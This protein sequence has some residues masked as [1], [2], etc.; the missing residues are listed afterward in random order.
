MN[1]TTPQPL[2]GTFSSPGEKVIAGHVIASVRLRRSAGTA[3]GWLR[4]SADGLSETASHGQRHKLNQRVQLEAGH[5]LLDVMGCGVPGR[6]PFPA[7]RPN[8]PRLHP[9]LLTHAPP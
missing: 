3:W 2:I 6:S 9:P 4:G 8:L 7:Y 1:Q 5:I